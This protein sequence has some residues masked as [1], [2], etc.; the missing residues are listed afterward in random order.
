MEAEEIFERGRHTG[1][2][3]DIRA[4]REKL[5]AVSS[6][7]NN[8]DLLV[9]TRVEDCGIQCLHHF[10]G[11]SVSGRIV[12]R[13]KRDTILDGKLNQSAGGFRFVNLCHLKVSETS[14][15]PV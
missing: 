13:Q 11:V 14:A 6:D 7:H 1:E 5:F 10:V 3:V 4:R 2:H 15:D 12:E 9:H 8:L